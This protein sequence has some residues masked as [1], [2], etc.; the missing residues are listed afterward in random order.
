MGLFS[1]VLPM[2]YAQ[3]HID[4][5]SISITVLTLDFVNSEKPKE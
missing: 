3:S 5:I 1:D 2:K 4:N